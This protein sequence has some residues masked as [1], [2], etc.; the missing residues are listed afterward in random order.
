ML[1]NIR[2]VIINIVAAFDTNRTADAVMGA[3]V[4]DFSHSE[5]AAINQVLGHYKLDYVLAAVYPAGRA[6]MSELMQR[7]FTIVQA[8]L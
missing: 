2:T 5:L 6:D 1:S 3:V 4:E 8:E 7:F